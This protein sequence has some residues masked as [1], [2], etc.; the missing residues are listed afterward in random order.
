M[1]RA[2]RIAKAAAEA[3]PLY[4]QIM[5]KAYFGTASPRSAIKAQCLH[6][7]G[8]IRDDVTHCT[9]FTC[10]LWAYRPYQIKGGKQ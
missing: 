10:P 5:Q 4:R 2:E 9:G 8:Y 1:T 3:S 6:C 7:V